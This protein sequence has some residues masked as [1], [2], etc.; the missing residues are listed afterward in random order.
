VSTVP[1]HLRGLLADAPALSVTEAVAAHHAHR[2]GLCGDLLGPLLV[3][4]DDLPALARLEQ[5]LPV[6]VVVGGGAGALGPALAWA[7]RTERIDLTGVRLALRDSATGELAHNARRAVAAVEAALDAGDLDEPSRVH[8]ALP[9]LPPGG[10]GGDWPAALDVLAAADLAVAL[11][12]DRSPDET[13]ATLT[14]A[15]DRE[16][17]FACTG[18]SARAVTG[19][20]GPGFLNA[21]VATRAS[22]DGADLAEVAAVLEQTDPGTLL[23][24]VE[25]AGLERARRW[26][27]WWSSPDVAASAA[28]LRTLGL[29]A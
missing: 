23:S 13:A 21:L 1:A 15:L 10:P 27:T 26:C 2:S 20:P 25:V 12:A 6:T 24:G 11:S 4:D 9:P 22:L 29:V 5:P 3:A 7:A 16:L 17:R 14:A 8:V 19:A 28:D 18:G